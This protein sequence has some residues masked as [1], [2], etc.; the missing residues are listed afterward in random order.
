MNNNYFLIIVALLTG[1]L[2]PVQAALN[3]AFGKTVGTPV[4]TGL[5]VFMVA[6]FV[7]LAYLLITR[8]SFPPPADW[9]KAPWY[10]YLGGV[11]VATYVIVIILVSPRLG[12]GNSIGLAVTGQIIAAIIIDHFGLIHAQVRTMSAARVL[13]A[14]LMI[15]GIFLVMK[16]K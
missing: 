9:L 10:S 13:G 6:F 4:L 11:T 8:A 2:I 16:K 12:I 5:V 3:N 1:A 15:V 14:L 7:T